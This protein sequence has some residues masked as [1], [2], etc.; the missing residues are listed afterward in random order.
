MFEV[1]GLDLRGCGWSRKDGKILGKQAEFEFSAL[2][3]DHRE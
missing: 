1:K 3:V 2:M